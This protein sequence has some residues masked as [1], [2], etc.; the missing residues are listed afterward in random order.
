MYE[1][2]VVEHLVYSSSIPQAQHSTAQSALHKAANEARA[3]QSA[4]TQA[5]RQSWREPSC[6]RA[7]ME[8]AAFSKR[9]KSKSAPLIE[10]L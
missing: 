2:F 7:F 10:I 6:S 3:D 4:K 1:H 5:S 8:L 9:T